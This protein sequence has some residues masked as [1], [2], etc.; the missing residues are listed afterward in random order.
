MH[1]ANPDTAIVVSNE[2]ADVLVCLDTAANGPRL[3]IKG[4]RTQRVI[5]LDPLELE[6]LTV[7]NHHD[8]AVFLDPSYS[9]NGTHADDDSD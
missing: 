2:F 3:M 8:L 4:A 5:Y 7:L 6:R 9:D 1:E